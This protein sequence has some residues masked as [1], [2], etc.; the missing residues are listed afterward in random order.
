MLAFSEVGSYF[1]PTLFQMQSQSIRTSILRDLYWVAPR[2]LLHDGHVKSLRDLVD[3]DR[4]REGSALY[5]R[6]YT[7]HE[8]TFRIPK[9]NAEEERALRKFAYF[10]DVPW[11]EK[12]LYWDY[13]K[14]R[15]EFGPRE[16]GVTP[17]R[18]LPAAPHPWCVENVT[19]IDDLILYLLTL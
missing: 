7:L 8:G 1:S 10:S 2:G 16:F 17:A 9:G 19:E 15:R 12:H 11:D 5:D 3:P 13:Q 6:Y 18:P 14:M 4:C